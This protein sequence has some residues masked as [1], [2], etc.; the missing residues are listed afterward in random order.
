MEPHTK[1]LT[2]RLKGAL[3]LDVEIEGIP[4]S[5]LFDNGNRIL[6]IP[7]GFAAELQEKVSGVELTRSSV[8]QAR[9]RTAPLVGRISSLFRL[10]LT[11]RVPE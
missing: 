1:R 8:S 5:I 4:V 11:V 9:V 6:S 7:E 3:G 2:I 10:P